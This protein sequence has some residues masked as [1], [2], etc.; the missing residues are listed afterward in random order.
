MLT[1]GEG[2]VTVFSSTMSWCA[3]RLILLYTRRLIFGVMSCDI[4]S[5]RTHIKEQTLMEINM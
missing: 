2:R 1:E 5:P 3:L 4:A